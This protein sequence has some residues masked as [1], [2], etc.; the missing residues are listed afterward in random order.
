MH[1]TVSEKQ[2]VKVLDHALYRH[3]SVYSSI[4]H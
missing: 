4:Y 1:Y 2:V 3:G